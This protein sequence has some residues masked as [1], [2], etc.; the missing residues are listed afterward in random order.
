[1]ALRQLHSILD[2]F[3]HHDIVLV[4]N[5]Y[6]FAIVPL[7]PS[8]ECHDLFNANLSCWRPWMS[9][10]NSFPVTLCDLLKTVI[11]V[12]IFS[13]AGLKWWYCIFENTCYIVEIAENKTSISV[14]KFKDSITN[15]IHCALNMDAAFSMFMS[16]RAWTVV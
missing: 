16:R 7:L 9:V 14:I 3:I 13:T 12:H 2:G 10:Y 6:V 1:M 8:K 5:S 11:A 15:F 4:V